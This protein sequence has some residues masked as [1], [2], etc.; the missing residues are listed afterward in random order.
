MQKYYIGDSCLCWSLSDTIDNAVSELVL[1]IFHKIREKQQNGE[2]EFWD[3][4]PSYNSIAV[5]FDPV[6]EKLTQ[7]E[8]A[9]DLIVE[10][11]SNDN[12]GLELESSTVVHR[13]P[14]VYDGEDL[15][16]VAEK[17]GLTVNEVVELH[18]QPKYRVA[19]IGFLPH[20]PYLI[21]LDPRLETPRLDSPRTKVPGG[22]VAIGG[23]Q[24][25]IYPRE[26]PGGWNLIGRTDPQ[27][28]ECIIPGDFVVFEKV[29]KL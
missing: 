28:L 7:L 27:L 4:V 25:G 17:N 29:D 1:R 20:Y 13:M 15:D 22:A 11:E 26:S 14:T 18:Q 23:V 2:L 10:A 5:Y 6:S 12:A 8:E 21:G 3:I 24:T 16:L 19:M 9:I